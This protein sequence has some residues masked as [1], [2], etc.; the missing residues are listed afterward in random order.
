MRNLQFLSV[1]DENDR[2]CIPGDLQFP[3]RLKLLHWE[4]YPRK[5]LPIRFYL[6]NL[7]ELDMR[8]SQLEKLWEGP[9]LLTNLKKMDLSMSRHLKELPDLSNATN[10]KRLN[11]DDCE[12]LVE[13]PSSFSNLHKL[14][15]LSMFACTK[16]EVI[17]TR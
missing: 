1:S 3:P 15:V 4:A 13:I 5:S 11:L 9:Q 2:I 10:L 14:K 16:L 7:V 12:S 8:N 17:P 6:E